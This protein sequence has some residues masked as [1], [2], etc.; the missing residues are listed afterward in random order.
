MA[1]PSVK[2][3]EALV[4][5][6]E[7]NE[8]SQ[9]LHMLHD[10]DAEAYL[11]TAEGRAYVT[12]Y[13]LQ[14]VEG[15]R[16]HL[17]DEEVGAATLD[18]PRSHSAIERIEQAVDDPA[19]DLAVSNDV[20]FLLDGL[21]GVEIFKDNPQLQSAVLESPQFLDELVSLSEEVAADHHS[22]DS[23]YEHEASP[24]AGTLEPD[25][26]IIEDGIDHGEIVFDHFNPAADMI[27]IVGSDSQPHD[28]QFKDFLDDDGELMST[29]EFR[30]AHEDDDLLSQLVIEGDEDEVHLHMEHDDDSDNEGDWEVVLDVAPPEDPLA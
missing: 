16:E 20:S 23:V 8:V 13:L 30:A 14:D 17:L 12:D 28:L 15:L 2:K 26:L 7:A 25:M 18:E 9:F 3:G 10:P 6:F 1:K 19:V 4:G 24:F 29:E 21:A 11:A 27:R 5:T 22:D